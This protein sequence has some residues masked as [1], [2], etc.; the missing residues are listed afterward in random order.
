MT[1]P[2]PKA[3]R[4]VRA[5]RLERQAREN[6]V[7]EGM[8]RCLNCK[9]VFPG[10]FAFCPK[11]GR[12]AEQMKAYRERLAHEAL[13]N[14][15][16][17]GEWQRLYRVVVF[18]VV[19]LVATFACAYLAL[20]SEGVAILVADGVMMAVT[21]I[22]LRMDWPLVRERLGLG[23]RPA[24]LAAVALTAVLTIA[25]T[26]FN[27]WIFLR[28]AGLDELMKETQGRE[29]FYDA[30]LPMAVVI[31]TMCVVPGIFEELFFRGLMQGTLEEFLSR[32]EA[33]I[34]QAIVFAIAHV[35]LVGF[36]TYLVFMGLY[37]GWLRN[38]SGSLIPGMLVH[39]LHNF[40]ATFA[41]DFLNP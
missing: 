41:L 39:F 20:G 37:L 1:P 4:G 24:V 8:Q 26:V 27:N 22:W 10:D 13:S 23:F 7:P 38:R 14:R 31:F 33:W 17:A 30:E 36:F 18:Y 9:E 12:N 29:A 6:A 34:V 28:L 35:N 16:A 11:C 2:G 32:K 25:V 40:F 21:L 5:L 15:R 3:P 19:L